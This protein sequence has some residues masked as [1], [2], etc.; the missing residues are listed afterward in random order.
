MM[1]GKR[2]I[3]FLFQCF[4]TR[5]GLFQ[6]LFFSLF[7]T[8]FLRVFLLLF[9]HFLNAL[10]LLV[11]CPSGHNYLPYSWLHLILQAKKN[12]AKAG[13]YIKMV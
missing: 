8:F 1:A 13:F 3:R 5:T 7:F 11:V 4:T 9:L 2:N 6:S 10:F 12:P